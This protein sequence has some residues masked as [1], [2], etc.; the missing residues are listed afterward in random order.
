M[1][2]A[3][4]HVACKPCH[5]LLKTGHF[6]YYDVASLEIRFSSLLSSCCSC[7]LRPAVIHF[8]SD[9]SKQFLTRSKSLS[10]MVREVILLSYQWSESDMTEISRKAWHQKEKEKKKKPSSLYRLALSWGNPPVLNQATS[11]LALAFTSCFGGSQRCKPG[12]LS[13]FC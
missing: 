7:L 9:I 5:F 11:N 6:E 2:G 12:F 4:S 8:F 13:D 1:N 3:C 10:Y